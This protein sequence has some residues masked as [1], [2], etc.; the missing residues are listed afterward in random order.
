MRD[1]SALPR[2]VQT[3]L[4][5]FDVPAGEPGQKCLH[6]G[7][8]F[9]GDD[10]FGSVE[11]A[12]DGHDRPHRRRIGGAVDHQSGQVLTQCAA[13]ALPVPVDLAFGAAGS[14]SVL[15]GDSSASARHTGWESLRL[16]RPGSRPS[17]PQKIGQMP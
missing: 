8:A 15:V 14:A 11:P 6:L 2:L 3:V 13:R 16:V 7:G 9:P 4:A 12:Q 10:A 1:L 17:C 5:E